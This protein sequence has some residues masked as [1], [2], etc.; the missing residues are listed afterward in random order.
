MFVIGG[1][2]LGLLLGFSLQRGGYCMN[3]AFRSFFYEKDRS[4]VR[5]WVLVLLI[6]VIGV[7]LLTELG[8]LYPLVAPFFWP[9]MIAG[10]F[11]F[12]VGMVLAGGCASGTYY[13]CGRG[14]LGSMGALLGFVLGT[15]LVD[16]GALTWLQQ[17]MR[18][19]TLDVRGQEATLFNVLGIE[20][21]GLRWVLLG[22]LAAA[23]MVWLL[24]APKQR[25]L[26]G[27]GWQRTGLVVGVLALAAWVLSAMAGRD[28]GLSFTQPTVALT[29][30]VLAGDDSGI[31]VASYMVIGVPAGAL[32]AAK[33]TGEAVLRI[34][35]PRTLLRQSGGGVTMGVGASLAGGCNIGH[36]ITGISTLSIGAIVATIFIMLGSWT[37][38]WLIV[39]S[40]SRNAQRA[41]KQKQKQQ[42]QQSRAKEAFV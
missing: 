19:P 18:Q 40:E 28:F 37:M 41:Q 32:L 15:A 30:Y 34:P 13:R 29:R 12:G 26:I 31:S 23:A 42:Q 2:A 5:A 25:F 24:R 6:N 17:S 14:M 21:A 36:S 7:Q 11:I 39:R 9:A 22:V 16:G 10:G 8:V 33:A 27:W 20:T 1:I 3:T 38:T 4:L 35:D